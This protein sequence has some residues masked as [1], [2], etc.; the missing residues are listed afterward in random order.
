[1]THNLLNPKGEYLCDYTVDMADTA[2]IEL[3]D[4]KSPND[5]SSIGAWL[6]YNQDI[7]DALLLTKKQII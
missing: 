1:M 2:I 3:Q 6:E 5:F 7:K 4:I